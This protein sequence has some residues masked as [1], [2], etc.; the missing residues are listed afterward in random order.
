MA[1]TII[2]VCTSNVCRSPV[3]E[4]LAKRWLQERNRQNEYIIISRSISTDYE[5]EN[6][7][8]SENSAKLLAEN[9]NINIANHRSRLLT[10]NDVITAH[11]I[12][13]ITKSHMH[14]IN[15][16]FPNAINKCY[17][18]PID[19]PDPWHQ[20]IQTYNRCINLMNDSMTQVFSDII[21]A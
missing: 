9:F 10:D 15:Y 1:Q 3:A 17:S 20:S 14:A 13:G 12:I 18:M 6:S 4:A 16:D 5:P 8:P 11:K 7:P 2:F 21:D 19:I